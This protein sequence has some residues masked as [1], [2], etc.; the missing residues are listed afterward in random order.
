MRLGARG[1]ARGRRT[2]GGGHTQ[3]GR[4]AG[5]DGLARRE[6]STGATSCRCRRSSAIA[7][8]EQPAQAK[9]ARTAA[10]RR[11]RHASARGG[12]GGQRPPGPCP[13]TTRRR[14]CCW[15]RRRCSTSRAATRRRPLAPLA[16]LEQLAARRDLRP[17]SASAMVL[18]RARSPRW[19]HLTTK[20]DVL[21]AQA[22]ARRWRCRLTPGAPGAVA[23][24]RRTAGRLRA[25]R[26]K[27]SPMLGPPPHGEDAIGRYIA[28]R[29]IEAHA[30]AG[31][32][33]A[34]ARG[35]ARGAGPALARARWRK[36]R[37]WRR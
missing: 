18:A 27:R 14:R 16:R 22:G 6:A 23:A 32:R 31:R 15:C 20:P 4:S 2:A 35:G 7:P 21:L 34:A 17:A 37:R 26:T 11:R 10:E 8:R 13:P 19:P 28:F 25:S 33:G 3:A 29:Q 1:R 36:I 12:A 9:V 30:R 5:G 24:A